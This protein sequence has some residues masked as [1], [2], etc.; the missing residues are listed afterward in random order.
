M[1]TTFE[2]SIKKN[3]QMSLLTDPRHTS[4][5][6]DASD[7]PLYLSRVSL[8]I[9]Q[10]LKESTAHITTLIDSLEQDD[11]RENKLLQDFSHHH[12]S[13]VVAYQLIANDLDVRK[14][15]SMLYGFVIK[16]TER[17]RPSSRLLNDSMDFNNY[18]KIK[19]VEWRDSSL[20]Q[21][22]NGI[23]FSKTVADR[24]MNYTFE[25]PKI[26]LLKNT[27][28]IEKVDL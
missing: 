8:E 9:P 14:W 3:R 1:F 22:V 16:A 11:L 4:R 7:S 21:Y 26:L 20:S 24:R 5:E 18:V 10:Q 23:V 15:H 6:K 19:I 27:L 25:N 2:E 17:I 12:I 13:K 28:E